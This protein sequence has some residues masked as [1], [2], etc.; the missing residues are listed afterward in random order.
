MCRLWCSIIQRH[1]T[2]LRRNITLKKSSRDVTISIP[3]LRGLVWGCVVL[4]WIG[5]VAQTRQ[6]RELTAGATD[7]ETTQTNQGMDA[8]AVQAL[9]LDAVVADLHVDPLFWNERLDVERTVRRRAG[10][11]DFAKLQAGG[12]DLAVLGLVTEGLPVINGFRLLAR[13]TGWPQGTAGDPWRAVQYQLDL[14]ER[15]LEGQRESSS[16]RAAAVVRGALSMR[17]TLALDWTGILL[18]LEGARMLIGLPERVEA[19]RARGLLYASPVHLRRSR[20]GGTSFPLSGG[21]PLTPEGLQV[22]R[23][24][25]RAGIWIDLAHLSEAAFW[26][27]LE[28]TRGPVLVSH[29]GMAGETPSWRNLTDTQAKAVAARGGVIGVIAAPQ[30]L[31]GRGLDAMVR[32]VVRAIRVVGAAHVALGT[33]LDGFVVP[34]RGLSDSSGFPALTEELLR[35]GIKPDDVTAILG[36]NFVRMLERFRPED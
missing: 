23:E 20:M 9:H 5:C 11:V 1:V 21:G 3:G 31:G 28:A 12:V 26:Q 18:G 35:G 14:L 27:V 13:A 36:G 16:K 2:L 10:L 22:V 7:L 25:E 19:L 24:L 15:S 8:K 30:Y 34:P 17:Q 29:T 4:C 32:H 6:A 33:D